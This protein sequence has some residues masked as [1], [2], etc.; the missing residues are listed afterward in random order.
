MAALKT[1]VQVSDRVAEVDNTVDS[2]FNWTSHMMPATNHRT[3]R[4][5]GEPQLCRHQQI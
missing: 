3:V 5:S 4:S 2:L 1:L